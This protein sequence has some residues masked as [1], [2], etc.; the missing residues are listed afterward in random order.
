MKFTEQ[1]ISQLRLHS[2]GTLWPGTTGFPG[3]QNSVTLS[4][5]CLVPPLLQSLATVPLPSL[6][7]DLSVL[8]ISY[9]Q[10]P[11]GLCFWRP[12]SPSLMTWRSAHLAAHA[13]KFIILKDPLCHFHCCLWSYQFTRQ[14]SALW[15][16]E[17]PTA[18]VR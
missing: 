14:R 8:D 12:P 5:F 1:N 7:L 2:P 9:Q 13:D 17:P 3:K 11:A 6:S 10:K 18:H 16:R 4:S 15:P